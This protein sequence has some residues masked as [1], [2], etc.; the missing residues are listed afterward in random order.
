MAASSKKVYELF[1]S[2]IPWTVANKE[3]R[4][5]FGQ[6]GNV[7]N[8]ILPFDRRT[9]F[10]KGFCWVGFSS[11]EGLNNSL[12]KEPHILEG[13]KLQVQK[14]Q[15]PFTHKSIKTKEEFEAE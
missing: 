9:G 1:V 5:Y 6:F 4:E 10:H 2:K 15:R 13:S 3:M 7:K 8:C 12:Q 11:E 14:N